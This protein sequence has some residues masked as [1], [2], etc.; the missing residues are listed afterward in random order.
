[1]AELNTR[2]EG[3]ASPNMRSSALCP[4]VFSFEDG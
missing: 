3:S 2:P 1:M 4:L